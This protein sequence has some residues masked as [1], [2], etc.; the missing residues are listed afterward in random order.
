MWERRSVFITQDT[1]DK[2]PSSAI[3]KYEEDQ[4]RIFF[5][6]GQIKCYIC[7]QLGHTTKQ[8]EYNYENASEKNPAEPISN[9]LSKSTYKRSK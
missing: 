4:Y 8:C 1:V 5:N 6:D 2:L 9:D 7:H 3:V